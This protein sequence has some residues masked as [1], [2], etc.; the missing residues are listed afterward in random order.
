PETMNIPLPGITVRRPA[1][2]GDDWRVT[3]GPLEGR[4]ATLGAAKAHLAAQL[5]LS[6][7]T[8]HVQPAFARDDDGALV[9]AIDR[10]WGI[11]WYRATD[12]TARLISTGNR[13]PEGPAADL[14]RVHHF[15]PLPEDTGSRAAGAPRPQLHTPGEVAEAM[16]KARE[17]AETFPGVENAL[18]IFTDA[19]MAT[20]ANPLAQYPAPDPLSTEDNGHTVT[21]TRHGTRYVSE[22]SQLPGR[23]FGPWDMAEMI[24]DLTFSALLDRPAARDLV[25][26][27]HVQGSAT[28]N[29]KH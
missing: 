13:I 21:V 15:T 23:S 2:R 14:A 29:T 16:A 26:D 25:M 27:A 19:T 20:L 10:P 18:D 8:L 5:T 12:A 17:T 11:D 6:V 7:E 9:V 1:R 3:L 24:R 28:T 4:G 22:F